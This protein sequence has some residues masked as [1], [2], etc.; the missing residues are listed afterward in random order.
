V[1][2]GE[3]DVGAAATEPI[4]GLQIRG[5]GVGPVRDERRRSRPYPQ[6]QVG[7][8]GSGARLQAPV[9]RP[10]LV[11]SSGPHGGLDELGQGPLLKGAAQVRGRSSSVQQRL[12]VLTGAVV[13][14]GAHI[15]RGTDDLVVAANGCVVQPGIPRCQIARVSGA[16]RV[17]CALD[18]ARSR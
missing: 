13:R 16:E 5:F 17:R 10:R 4:D 11:E 3:Q 12:G 8:G 2:P 6:G 7:S 18:F 14:H 1:R 9:R 15:L